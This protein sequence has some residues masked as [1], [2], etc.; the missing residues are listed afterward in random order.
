MIT[1]HVNSYCSSC[2]KNKN[3]TSSK[4]MFYCLSC[5]THTNNMASRSVTLTNKVLRQ[6]SKYS[7][8]FSD[9]SRF[10]KQ[11]HGH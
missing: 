5:K 4:Y 3:N 7:V 2:K 1:K 11:K 6:K 9:K 10:L 8:C